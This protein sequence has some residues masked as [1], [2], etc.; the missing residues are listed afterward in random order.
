MAEFDDTL[1]PVE[2]LIVA[3][4]KSRLAG[5]GDNPPLLMLEFQKN[6][7]LLNRSGIRKSLVAEREI[8]L[9][10]LKD[11]FKKIENEV[12]NVE[13]EWVEVTSG[14]DRNK[15]S[16]SKEI[17]ATKS[18]RIL[19]PIANKIVKL[20]QLS[21]KLNAAKATSSTVLSDLDGYDRFKQS[22]DGLLS[23]IQQVLLNFSIK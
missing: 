21:D 14:G 16:N 15:R 17:T 13:T 10:S 9:T 18:I 12:D 4:F 3:R 22:A 23:R 6:M 2:N 8:L 19:T 20:R 5:Q 11:L 1:A 7:S